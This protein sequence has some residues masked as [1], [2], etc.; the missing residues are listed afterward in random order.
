MLN[1]GDKVEEITTGRPG[2]IDKILC[3][4]PSGKQ[5]PYEWQVRFTDGKAPPRFNCRDESELKNLMDE[6]GPGISPAE[7]IQK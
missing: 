4:G 3:E 5:V 7:P 2:E 1:A 6:P